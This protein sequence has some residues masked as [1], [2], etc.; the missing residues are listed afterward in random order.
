VSHVSLISDVPIRDID[1]LEA[2]LEELRE[3]GTNIYMI[4]KKGP[5]LFSSDQTRAYAKAC[6]FTIALP[7]AKY[8]IGVQP[9][10]EKNEAIKLE[11]LEKNPDKLS[12]Y[13][14]IT[15]FWNGSIASQLSTARPA[16]NDEYQNVFSL[17]KLMTGYSKYAIINYALRNGCET[18]EITVDANGDIEFEFEVEAA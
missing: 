4:A 1:A 14:L 11:D 18:S 2:A 9:M 6:S 12:H 3:G 13:N 15:D 7:N 16:D 10:D 17:G 5:R 8:D